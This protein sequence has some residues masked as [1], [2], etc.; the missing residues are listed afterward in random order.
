MGT[1][2]A[3]M[4]SV[5]RCRVIL[6]EAIVHERAPIGKVRVI[7]LIIGL[8]NEELNRP[9]VAPPQLDYF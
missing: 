3:F 9:V 1:R 5:S 8:M 7:H 4:Q 2:A 6:E